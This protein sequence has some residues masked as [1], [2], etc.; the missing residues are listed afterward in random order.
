M[1]RKRRNVSPGFRIPVPYD[2]FSG[3]HAPLNPPRKQYCDFILTAELDTSD[4]TGEAEITEQYGNGQSHNVKTPIVIHNLREHTAATYVFEGDVG[5]YGRAVWIYE[6]HW[7]I[8]NMEC[9]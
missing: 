9:P 4:E 8:L 2:P 3:D 1:F 7:L 5:D 6:N